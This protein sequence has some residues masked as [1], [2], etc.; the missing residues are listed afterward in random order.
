MPTPEGVVVVLVR[1]WMPVPH[2]TL[3]APYPLQ[4]VWTQSTVGIG[5]RLGWK[6]CHLMWCGCK[7]TKHLLSPSS[8]TLELHT[9]KDTTQDCSSLLPLSLSSQKDGKHALVQAGWNGK[10]YMLHARALVHTTQPGQV[11]PVHA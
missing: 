1:V 7:F 10:C 8:V 5:T 11:V 4:E 6:L 3:H 9:T 2:A